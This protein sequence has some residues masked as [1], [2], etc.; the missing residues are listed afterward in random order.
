MPSAYHFDARARQ[1]ADLDFS[2]LDG[3]NTKAEDRIL[4]SIGFKPRRRSLNATGA[5]P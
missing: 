1:D 4:A 5:W 2:N 3:A